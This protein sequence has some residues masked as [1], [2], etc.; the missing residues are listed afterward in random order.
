MAGVGADNELPLNAAM[1]V[2]PVAY[3]SRHKGQ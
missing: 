3:Y 1:Q 2:R